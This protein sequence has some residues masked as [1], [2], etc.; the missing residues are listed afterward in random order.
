MEHETGDSRQ[1]PE[2]QGALTRDELIAHAQAFAGEIVRW[3]VWYV[4]GY[5]PG[6]S[7]A[8]LSEAEAIQ[9]LAQVLAVLL[10]DGMVTSAM[11]KTELT[12]VASFLGYTLQDRVPEADENRCAPHTHQKA[13]TEPDDVAFLREHG[14]RFPDEEHR[15]DA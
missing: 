13:Q 10:A 14:L 3:K 12:K 7:Q 5:E 4:K 1:P 2:D 6:P 9:A 15:D 8:S 11:V